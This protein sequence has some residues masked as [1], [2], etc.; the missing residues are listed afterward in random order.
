VPKDVDD[1][2]G[3]LED[4]EEAAPYPDIRAEL[5]GVELEEEERRFQTVL[6][7]P[8]PDFWDMAAAALHNAG[9]DDNKT[10]Q[11]G[12]A[13]ALAAAHAVQGGAA[14]V[15]AN[16][17]ELVYEITSDVPDKGLL[18]LPLGEDRDDTSIPVIALNDDE[19][20]NKIQDVRRYPTQA[21][22]SAVGNQP[23]DTYAPRRTFLQLGAV[24]A[25]RSVLET[26]RLT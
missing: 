11:A 4:E 19:T 25:H 14:L 3:L 9:I 23:Y 7:K 10:I 15:E 12:R 20:H 5:P 24:R 8:E 17:N 18:Q 22:R 2:Q 21:R 16:E 26:S 6:D 1:F 13:R